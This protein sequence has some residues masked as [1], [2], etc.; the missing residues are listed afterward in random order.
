MKRED[1]C[2]TAEMPF[3]E[4][5]LLTEEQRKA[6]IRALLDQGFSSADIL[7]LAPSLL[8]DQVEGTPILAIPRADS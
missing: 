3:L 1:P 4:T 5:T 2:R 6:V 7:T 8:S